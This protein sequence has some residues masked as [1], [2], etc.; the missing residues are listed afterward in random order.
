MDDVWVFDMMNILMWIAFHLL[1]ERW[2]CNLLFLKVLLL[3]TIMMMVMLM[4][5]WWWLLF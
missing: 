4:M 3:L 5:I 1:C 2:L